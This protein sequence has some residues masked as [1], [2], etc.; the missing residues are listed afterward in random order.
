MQKD[1]SRYKFKSEWLK[2]SQENYQSQGKPFEKLE[3]S[4]QSSQ[5]DQEI[6]QH[7]IEKRE[8][9]IINGVNQCW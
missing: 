7:S 5:K 2:I 9:A 4:E 1:M 8:L 3:V 6:N